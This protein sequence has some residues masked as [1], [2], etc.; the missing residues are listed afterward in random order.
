MS[1]KGLEYDIPK[2]I[3]NKF[4]KSKRWIETKN[5]AFARD[6]GRDLAFPLQEVHDRAIAH[7]INPLTVEDIE[8]LTPA[9]FDLD[10]IVTT[11]ITTHNIVH[12]GDPDDVYEERK[13]G[14]TR[15][16]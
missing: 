7:H 15:L 2:S 11:S 12:Y 10:N 5:E 14:D 1:L 4:Y 16:W 13:P 8:N 9:C 3:S 6:L